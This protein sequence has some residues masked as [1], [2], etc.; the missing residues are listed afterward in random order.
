MSAIRFRIHVESDMPSSKVLA[1]TDPFSF[2]MALST[3]DLQ[4]LPTVRG[5]FSAQLT[6]ICMD[7]LWM[8]R[9]YLNLPLIVAG[10]IKPGR[11]VFTFLTSSKPTAMR[12]CGVDVQPGDIIVNNFDEMHQRT[13][14]EFRLGTMSLATDDFDAACKALTGREFSGSPQKQFVRPN[15]DLMS[16]LLK[17]H[18]LVGQVAETTPDILEI[19]GAMRSLEQRLIHLMVGC[20]TE[21]VPSPMTSGGCRR[22]NIVG[23]FEAYLEAHPGKPLYLPEICAAIGIAE[24]TLRGA[25]QENLGMGPIRYLALRRMHLVRQALLRADRHST[26]ITQIATGHGFWELGRFAVAY[27]TLFGE[28]PSASLRRPSNDRQVS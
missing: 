11:R 24:R 18:E 13:H 9:C 28:T 8:Q 16:R 15:A 20:L 10:T 3:A 27:R 17:V 26:T 2:Q 21:G 25:C 4:L 1:F 5:K 23:R 7:Q 22:D 19:P 14:A 6:K 12:H